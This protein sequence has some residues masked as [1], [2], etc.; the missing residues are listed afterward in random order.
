MPPRNSSD[1]WRYPVSS[2][3]SRAAQ[4]SGSSPTLSRTPAG[5]SSMVRRM[6]GRNCRTNRTSPSGVT[7]RT[8]AAPGWRTTSKSRPSQDSTSTRISRPAKASLD[9]RGSTEGPSAGD[10]DGA[11][12]RSRPTGVRRSHELPEE[13]VRPGGPGPKLWMELAPHEER[14]VGQLDDLDQS[15]VGREAREHQPVLREDPMVGRVDLV[16]VPVTLVHDLLPVGCRGPGPRHQVAGLCPQAHRA[17]EVG[18]VLLL[19]QEIDHRVRGRRVE[20]RGVRALEATHVLC[21]LDD[22]ALQAQAQA[23][24]RHATLPRVADRLELSL[25]APPPEPARHYDAVDTRQHGAGVGLVELVR[26]HPRDVHLGT[27]VES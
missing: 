24:E 9:D 26:R 12:R 8:A 4:P 23:E 15:P 22:R 3:S 10:G 17:T 21:V 25:D 5:I 19:G 20:L 16:A 13:W 18:D 7:G 6:A 14:M 11:L 1:R 2:N 27:V